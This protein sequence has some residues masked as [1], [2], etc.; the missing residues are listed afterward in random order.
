MNNYRVYLPDIAET[1]KEQNDE[2]NMRI[3]E[4]EVATSLSYPTLSQIGTSM[5][6]PPSPIAPPKVP[7]KNP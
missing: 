2:Q 1:K 5:M 7:A 6:A 4:L 3:D